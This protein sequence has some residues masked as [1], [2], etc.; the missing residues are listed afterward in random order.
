MILSAI[1]EIV[2][3]IFA[4]VLNHSR[5]H[6]SHFATGSAILQ[7]CLVILVIPSVILRND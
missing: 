3:V 6:V 1:F 7:N 5:D 2:S 4:T